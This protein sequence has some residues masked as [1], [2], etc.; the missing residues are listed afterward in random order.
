MKTPS[1]IAITVSLVVV[2]G[3]V[4][5]SAAE[6]PAP[7]ARKDMQHPTSEAKTWVETNL[8]TQIT[9]VNVLSGTFGKDVNG[10]LV[11]YATLY[12]EPAQLAI[13]DPETAIVRSVL[14]IPGGARGFY[15]IAFASDGNLYLGSNPDGH[16]YRYS[17]GAEAVEDLGRVWDE[18]SFVWDLAEGPRGKLYLATYPQGRLVEYDIAKGA[19][20]DFG[21][22]VEGEDYVRSVTWDPRGQ[23]IYAGVG[24]HAA[25][26]ELDPITGEKRDILPEEYNSMHFVYSLDAV[27][28]KLVAKLDPTYEALVIDIKTREVE[29]IFPS[30]H[31][32][33]VSPLTADGKSFYYTDGARLM[34][35]DLD[36]KTLRQAG[37]NV[38]GNANAFALVP[39]PGG[40][41][42]RLLNLGKG[43]WWAEYTIETGK[44]KRQR[45]AYP[46]SPVGIQTVMQGPDGN[47]YTSGY[48]S[49][50]VARF[51]PRTGKSEELTGV[52]QSE[53]MATLGSRIY[54]GVYPRARIYVFDTAKPW[55]TKQGNPRLLF[56]LD[57]EEQ[58]RPYGMTGVEEGNKLFVGTV[59]AY[60][61]LGG[62]LAAYDAGTTAP[63]EIHRNLIP[64]QSIVSLVNTG[65][66]VIGGT[67]VSG[68]LGV[69]AEATEG[70]LFVWDVKKGEKAFETSP[71]PQ[72][73]AV[74]GLTVAPDGTVWGWADDN[75]FQFDPVAKKILHK[76]PVSW[77]DYSKDG[78]IWRG[79][80]MTDGGDGFLYGVVSHN[81]F[82]VDRESRRLEILR[83]GYQQL[84]ARDDFGHFYYA[85]DD[86]LIQVTPR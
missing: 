39:S 5:S 17:P 12:G 22:L 59:P 10:E 58:D 13:V 45:V 78:H 18:C 71:V 46:R 16:L 7:S 83:E 34:A 76:V 57:G 82:R 54:F 37:A 11:A 61:L 69:K 81:F 36:K 14:E 86:E 25:L 35:Y 85:R 74:T 73:R 28:G 19:F 9:T 79:A 4:C 32:V 26:I 47:I 40:K 48:L 70:R 84:I 24:S 64:D 66:L 53:G 8:G 1:L 44:V 68:G 33:H 62:A 77:V 2:M 51:N 21:S 15:G 52:G 72:K 29:H 55:D 56:Q 23:K 42:T 49:G 38:G 63:P 75:L 3:L 50:G 43:G 60:G 41:K 6:E 27:G 65:G 30:M 20:R 31:S 80:R 67:S